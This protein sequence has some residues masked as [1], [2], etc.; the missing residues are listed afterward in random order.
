MTYNPHLNP[1]TEAEYEADSSIKLL[2]MQW[3]ANHSPVPFALGRLRLAITEV[4]N[5]GCPFCYNEGS[6]GI[7]RRLSCDYIEFILSAA[8][9]YVKTI[10]LTGGEPLL[11][12]DFDRVVELC[13]DSRPTSLT[14]NGSKLLDH[15][16]SLSRLS[17]ITVSIQSLNPNTYLRSMGTMKSPNEI[18]EVIGKCRSELSVPIE[19]NCVLTRDN[20]GSLIDFCRRMS[21]LGVVKTN[22]L[23]FLKLKDSDADNYVSLRDIHSQLTDAFGSPVAATSTRLRYKPSD[24]HT[25][26]LVYQFCMVGCDVCRTDGFIRIDPSPSLSYCLAARR[27]PLLTTLERKDM[28]ALREL[29]EAAV[30][31]MGAP[32]GQ[33][34]LIEL[35]RHRNFIAG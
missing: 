12:P 34:S 8:L 32:T 10:K 2:R 13:A 28:R 19:V 27:I 21:G 33:Q 15:L 35:P 30:R 20:A 18:I 17:S 7:S 3:A 25:I 24:N 14:T 26:D 6:D 1:M 4:C 9:P 23:G 5:Y 16:S 31:S 22:L 11:H 29:F